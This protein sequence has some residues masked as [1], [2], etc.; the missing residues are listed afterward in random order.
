MSSKCI[1]SRIVMFDILNVDMSL[2]TSV[3]PHNFTQWRRNF[4]IK[5]VRHIVSLTNILTL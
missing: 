2:V 1:E 4:L 3:P 5:D